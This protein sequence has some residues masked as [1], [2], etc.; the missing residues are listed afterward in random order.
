MTDK[1]IN[2]GMR[3]GG[4]TVHTDNKID[5]IYPF[6]GKVIGTVPAGTAEHAQKAFDIAANYKPNLSRYDRQ[7]ILQKTA[8]TLVER[9]EQ[10][11]DLISLESGLSKQDTLYEVGRA[12]DVFSLTAQLCIQDDGEIYSCLLYTSPSPRDV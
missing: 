10:I 9:K 6:T 1:I 5:V 7:K 11:S 12:F 4:K 3:I 2:E 8:E